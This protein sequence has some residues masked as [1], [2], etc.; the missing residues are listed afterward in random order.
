MLYPYRIFEKKITP[1]MHL[2]HDE[3]KNMIKREIIEQLCK[4]KLV[5]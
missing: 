5:I 1:N 2:K 4:T 3:C